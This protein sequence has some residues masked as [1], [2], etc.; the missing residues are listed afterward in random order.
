MLVFGSAHVV[1]H[2]YNTHVNE[3]PESS[4]RG[5]ECADDIAVL[6]LNPS[7]M[8]TIINN[9]ND[10]ALQMRKVLEDNASCIGSG[11][12]AGKEISSWIEKAR[13]AF[14]SLR[15][16]RR[17]HD[18]MSSSDRGKTAVVWSSLLYGS[19]TWFLRSE[20]IRKLSEFEYRRLQ[21]VVRVS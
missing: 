21:S 11:E 6:G 14:A 5:I 12:L 17:R 16:L 2:V 7:K 18:V 1:C 13:A 10:S 4:R 15:H 8:Q 9:L 3:G 20:D 19:E